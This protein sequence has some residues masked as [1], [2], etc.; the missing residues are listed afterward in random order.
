MFDD[1]WVCSWDIINIYK[2]SDSSINVLQYNNG[3]VHTNL[4]NILTSTLTTM[5]II[6]QRYY[7]FGLYSQYCINIFK[8][9]NSLKNLTFG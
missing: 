4:M 8:M 9:F 6:S 7:T 2:M 5:A 1:I 3:I